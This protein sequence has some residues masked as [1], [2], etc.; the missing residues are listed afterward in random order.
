[1]DI[2]TLSNNYNLYKEKLLRKR[3][4]KYTDFCQVINKH[5]DKEN[6]NFSEPEFS[7]EGR[8]IFVMTYGTGETK[9]LFFLKCTATNLFRLRHLWIFSTFWKPTKTG[10]KK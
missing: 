5:L 3:R 4:F 7:F 10:Q 1:M 8:K 9:F 2:I 6:I